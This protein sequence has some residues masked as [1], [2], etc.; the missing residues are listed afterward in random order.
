MIDMILFNVVGFF[1]IYLM[2]CLIDWD[3][4][5]VTHPKKWKPE[6]RLIFVVVFILLSLL[7]CLNWSGLGEGI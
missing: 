5:T 7:S 2:W 4:V 1:I 3:I 6:A